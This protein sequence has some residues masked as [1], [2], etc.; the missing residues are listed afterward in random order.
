M[1]L[2]AVGMADCPESPS[3]PAPR[4]AT[5]CPAAHPNQRSQA[6]QT[7]SVSASMPSQNQVGHYSVLACGLLQELLV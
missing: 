4:A 2:Q 3:A 1:F 5:R 6:V 7:Q